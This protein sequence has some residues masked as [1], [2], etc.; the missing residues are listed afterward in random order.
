L[1]LPVPGEIDLGNGWTLASDSL[2]T[3]GLLANAG[4]SNP[5]GFQAWVDE[6]SLPAPLSVRCRLPGDRFSPLGMD[7]QSLKLSDFMINVKMPRRA[8]P[9]WPLV[10]SGSEIVWVPG[11]RLAHPFRIT[12]ETTRAVHMRL[13]SAS[14]S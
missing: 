1:A 14:P 8:R 11:Y 6:A 3:P 4:S 9:G 10:V 2:S 7:G 12:P 5:G 13:Y